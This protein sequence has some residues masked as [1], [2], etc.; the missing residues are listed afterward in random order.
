MSNPRDIALLMDIAASIERILAFT[1]GMTKEE[2]K[3][4]SRTHL[5]VQHQIMVIGEAAKQLSDE[6]R[7]ELTQVP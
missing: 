1:E 7:S 2:F 6:L 4:D 3:G 5:A